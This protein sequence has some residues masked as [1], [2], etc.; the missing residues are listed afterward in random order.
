ML[1]PNNTCIP[2]RIATVSIAPFGGAMRSRR[3]FNR[4]DIGCDPHR[5]GEVA[6]ARA[7]QQVAT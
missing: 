4:I 2:C 5:T 7:A 1:R 6:D 3:H